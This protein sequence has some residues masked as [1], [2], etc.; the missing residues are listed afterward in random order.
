MIYFDNAATTFKKPKS[1]Y[2]CVNS[3]LKNYSGNPGR[4]SHKLSSKAAELVYSARESVADLFNYDNPERVVFT[5][6]ATYAL[7]MAIKTMI[8][9][10]C[11][12]IISDVE[13]NS[14]L[15]P[16]NSLHDLIGIEYSVFD[17]SAENLF[18]EIEKLIRSDT[19]VIISTLVSN[20]DG[21]DI[22]LEILTAITQK[23][24]LKLIVDASQAAGHKNIDLSANKCDAIAM[25]GHKGLFG[26]Q[27]VGICIFSGEVPCET[28]VE[29]GSGYNSKNIYMPDELPEKF[30]AGTLPAPAI[31]SLNEGIRFIKKKTLED[32]AARIEMLDNAMNVRLKD[33]K[34]IKVFGGKN[35]VVSFCH[36]RIGSEKIATE[37]DRYG[38]CTRAGFHCAPLAHK[39]LGTYEK[40]TVRAS[41]S[42]FN[43]EK[44][45]DSFWVALNKIIKD[46][47]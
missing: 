29:G 32:I 13:H 17:S 25:P 20:V 42:Y 31:I 12:V 3:Y 33:I 23:H 9:E 6:N 40:G 4:G 41:F 27:G 18:F 30:E 1:V 45:I 38:I 15:R 7:N 36:E 16:L 35:G 10:R 43:S 22:P 21:R 34:S 11:H 39:T 44:E 8:T 14:V 5:M 24:N 19:K 2:R 28:F 46:I 47:K 37:L 26:I